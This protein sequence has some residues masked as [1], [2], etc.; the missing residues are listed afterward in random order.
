MTLEKVYFASSTVLDI[1]NQ[2]EANTHPLLYAHLPYL[3]ISKFPTERYTNSR[4]AA[5]ACCAANLGQ[6][7]KVC[8][9][10]T[11]NSIRKIKYE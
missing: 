1:I 9:R 10:A 4:P 5:C 3:F 7:G 11:R 6:G 8:M 2:N